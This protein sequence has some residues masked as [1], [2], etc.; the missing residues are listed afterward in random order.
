MVSGRKTAMIRT[1]TRARARTSSI[2]L[3]MIGWVE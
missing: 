3:I 1:T 2:F